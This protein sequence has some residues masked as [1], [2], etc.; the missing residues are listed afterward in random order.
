MSTSTL[1]GRDIIIVG[2]GVAGLSTALYLAKSSDV[3]VTVLDY[4]PYLQNGYSPANGCDAASADINKIMRASYGKETDYQRLAY[5][6]RDVWVQ[7]NRDL[8]ATPAEELPPA[9]TPNTQIF[10]P[11]GFIRLTGD[12][13]IPLNYDEL[14][15]LETLTP[16][17][18]DKNYILKSEQDRARAREH[19]GSDRWRNKTSGLTNFYRCDGILD[20]TAGYTV[21]D[22]ACAYAQF[23]CQKAGVKFVFGGNEGRVVKL[24]VEGE[25]GSRKVIGVETKDGK[26]HS[27]GMVIVAC[28]G[29]T[30]GLVP[31]V[32]DRLEATAGSVVLVQLPPKED[33]PDLWDKYSPERFAVWSKGFKDVSGPIGNIYGFPT[34]ENGILKIGYRGLKWTNFAEHPLAPGLRISV[35]KTKFTAQK[36]TRIP[37]VAAEVIKHTI[38][39]LFPDLIGSSKIVATRLCWY[40]DSL[41][42]NFLVDYVPGYNESLFVVSGGSGHMFKFLPVLGEN[43]LDVLLHKDTVYTKMWK[44]PKPEKTTISWIEKS[45]GL[46]E[47]ELGPRVL[48]KLVMAET[49]DLTY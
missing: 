25:G 22:K 32:A 34:T 21:A 46:E 19:G 20:M 30:A 2:A 17:Q 29:W 38:K 35:P 10:V 11:C 6:A 33:R 5:R 12:V 24:V 43:V 41:D 3:H 1:S 49:D 39:A 9:L 28:G 44:W 42:N 36:E 47:G 45:N 23:L 8:A 37:L 14:T 16:E 7:W 31:E 4:Q 18:R 48:R 40:C 27:G 26:T 15:G 13:S